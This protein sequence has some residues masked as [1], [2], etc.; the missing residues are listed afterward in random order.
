MWAVLW[1]CTRESF[2]F[3]VRV[4]AKLWWA[5]GWI[6]FFLLVIW[7]ASEVIRIIFS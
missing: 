2:Y 6:I 3:S 7:L 4:I 5:T 1:V